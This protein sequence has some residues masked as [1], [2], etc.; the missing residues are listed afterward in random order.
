MKISLQAPAQ[1]FTRGQT[2][3]GEVVGH[4]DG[5]SLAVVNGV[6]TRIPRHLPIG[7]TFSGN[8]Q[9]NES[10]ETV[11]ESQASDLKNR[12]ASM[13]ISHP[14]VKLE[15]T[16]E[17]RKLVELMKQFGI[18]ITP[19]TLE[20]IKHRL[21][22][23]SGF[24]DSAK[25][26]AILLML[27]R[28]LPEQQLSALEKYF[29]GRQHLAD[30]FAR[31]DS[32]SLDQLRKQWG[33]GRSVTTLIEL[34]EQ[35]SSE[36]KSILSQTADQLAENL[37]FQS[38]FEMSPAESGDHQLYFQW[39]LFWQGQ[40]APDTLEGECFFA[41]KDGQN[42][43]FSV[44]VM[45]HPPN[46]GNMEIG[47]HEFEKALWVHFGV[48]E[49][50]ARDLLP[51]VFEPLRHALLDQGWKSVKLTLGIKPPRSQLLEPLQTTPSEPEHPEL[52]LKA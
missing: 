39:P 16:P 38:L 23:G 10:G 48:R 22:Q 14:Q 35:S 33:L 4:Q 34:I 28:G 37:Q 27:S 44:R 52:D 25:L 51:T 29:S 50:S 36:G 47:I 7:H 20:E 32:S 18:P 3:R 26:R 31:L 11:V 13:Q 17:N 1:A 12:A 40:N 42:R 19:E 24:A 45:V 8:I 2:V 41:R 21:P 9:Q 30:L 49:S 43:G 15:P 6:M 5:Q 46:L